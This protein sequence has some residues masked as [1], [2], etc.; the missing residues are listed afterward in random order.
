[1]VSNQAVINHGLVSRQMVDE[2]NARMAAAVQEAGGR[3]DSVLYCPHR[4]DENCDCRKPRPGLLFLTAERLGLDLA[5][6]FLVGDAE[7]DILVAL[8]AGC[9]PVLVKTGRGAEQLA[10]LRQHRVDAFHVVDDLADA[11]EWIVGQVK[12]CGTSL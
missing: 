1:V 7:S 12:S 8:S 6:S 5:H 10:L 3:I 9:R 11:V 2:I 4:P